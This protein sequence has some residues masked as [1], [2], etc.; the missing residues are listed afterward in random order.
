MSFV[1]IKRFS[2]DDG[3]EAAKQ[4]QTFLDSRKVNT[5]CYFLRWH[6]AVSGIIREL[7]DL[8]GR[9]PSPEGQMFTATWEIRW[10]KCRN[11]YEVLL[12]S[13]DGMDIDFTRLVRVGII[14]IAQLISIPKVKH[15][16]P[17]SLTLQQI[18]KTKPSILLNDTSW[19][20]RPEI[21]NLLP[22]P[23]SENHSANHYG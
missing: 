10:V 16:F 1:G 9:F 22:S 2:S 20:N 19:I 7:T 13:T 4:L 11:S 18:V 17:R 12:L 14:A 8:P 5:C 6:H 15:A 23:S 21:S 3:L